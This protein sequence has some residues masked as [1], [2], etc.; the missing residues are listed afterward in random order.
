MSAK[1]DPTYQGNND[2]VDAA[3]INATQYCEHYL[4]EPYLNSGR[5]F[6][7]IA[8]N[9]TSAF[10]PNYMLG[11][12][13]ERWVQAALGVPVNFTISSDAVYEAF[14][15]TGD[16]SRGGLLQDIAYVLDAGI[17]VAMVYGDRDFACNW[18]GGEAASL[19][20]PYSGQAKFA[21]AGY[22]DIK[23]NSSYVGGQVRQ[24]GNFSFSRVY[25]SGHEVPAYQPETAFQ[26]FSRAMNNQDIATGNKSTVTGKNATYSTTGP[27][28]TWSIKNKVPPMTPLQCYV[29][30]PETCS[31]DQL[32]DIY[33]GT[34]V[35]KD[36]IYVGNGTA[37]STSSGANPSSSKKSAASSDLAAVPTLQMALLLLAGLFI[38]Y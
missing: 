27:S 1:L 3:C 5:D 32:N 2:Q 21:A 28:D 7:D 17:K 10:P 18:I 30:A 6:Y 12:L 38:V 35:L 19:A 20:V 36:Y 4:E 31:N 14:A 22:T 8:A 33:Y 25:E 24:Y 34:A 13:N 9:S 15:S 29:L 26:I 16:Y 11:F 37:N 23:V